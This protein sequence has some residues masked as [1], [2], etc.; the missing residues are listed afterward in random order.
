MTPDAKDSLRGGG[1][2]RHDVAIIGGGPVGLALA[3]ELRLAGMSVIVLE[4]LLAIDPTIKAGSLGPLAGEALARRS[5]EP[6]MAA[7]EGVMLQQMQAMQAMTRASGSAGGG[8]G[9]PGPAPA[10]PPPATSAASAPSAPARGPAPVGW[11]MLRTRRGRPNGGPFAGMFL[12]EQEVQAEPWRRNRGVGQQ[13]LE[14]ML[15][16]RAIE[17]GAELRRGYSLVGFDQTADGVAITARGPEGDLALTAGYLVG[18]DGG[19]SLV[20]KLAGFEFPGTAPT[21]TGYQALVDLADPEKLLPLGWRRTPVG[22]LAYGP[23]PGRI[24]T[25]EFDGPPG[26]RDA[27]I[28]KDELQAALRRVSGTDVT[29]TAVRT[30]TRWTDNARQ[31]STYR[32]GRVLLAGDAAHIHSPFG[33]QGLNLGIGDAFNLGWKL[34]ATIRGWAPDGLLDTYTAERHPVAARVLANTRA[35]VALMR[36]GPHVDALRDLVADL[37]AIDDVN[38]YF[39]SMLGGLDLRYPMPGDHPLTGRP[40]GDLAIVLPDG[41]ATTTA[42]L[43]HDGR[44]LLVDLDPDPSTALAARVAGLSD[45]IQLVHARVE[46]AAGD[47]P[48]STTAHAAPADLAAVLVRPDGFVAWAAAPGAVD[49]AG[50]DAAL[51]TWFTR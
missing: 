11:P 12:I 8:G 22:M 21:I 37:L 38:R 25:V 15:G 3:I 24:L 27:P 41:T 16:R 4:R 18:C 32:L 10:A 39:G 9:V 14:D 35:Q 2:P 51:R 6:A 46:P 19:K 33:G 36:P 7:V 34:A 29:I 13:A 49:L 28:T 50:L 30:A 47:S 40:W 17:L 20:R 1:S 48:L 44:A 23:V 42:A 31:A 5:L 45:R 43:M 26:D